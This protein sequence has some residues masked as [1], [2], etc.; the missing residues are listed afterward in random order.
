MKNYLKI[1]QIGTA[2]AVL[3]GCP[4]TTGPIEPE[5]PI[6]VNPEIPEYL[7]LSSTIVTDVSYPSAAVDGTMIFENTAKSF[8]TNRMKSLGDQASAVRNF[9]A[10]QDV[11]FRNKINGV[12]N[13]IVSNFLSGGISA[14]NRVNIANNSID[15]VIDAFADPSLFGGDT[16]AA[17]LYKAQLEAYV[18]AQFIKQREVSGVMDQS[19]KDVYATMIANDKGNVGGIEIPNINDKVKVGG[20]E[21]KVTS[22]AHA[23][24][25]ALTD[26]L[27][28]NM[29]EGVGKTTLGPALLRQLEDWSQLTAWVK[30]IKTRFDGIDLNISKATPA[31]TRP[32]FEAE[33][34]V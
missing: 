25:I 31:Q 30:D 32:G 16:Q 7:S 33:R 3:T 4:P 9:S 19:D 2:I 22:D 23:M 1:I 12:E 17:N 18:N 20:Q 21:T 14:D 10:E 11:S 13:G 5:P 24:V 6:I 8:L 28:T 34:L 27:L 15:E 29:P 26:T